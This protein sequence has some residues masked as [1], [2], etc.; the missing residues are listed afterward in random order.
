MNNIDVFCNENSTN[1]RS[2][3]IGRRGGGRKNPLNRQATSQNEYLKK[4]IIIIIEKTTG[5]ILDPEKENEI[6]MIEKISP[7]VNF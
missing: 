2:N 4:G 1:F 3:K 7:I 5:S 6:I